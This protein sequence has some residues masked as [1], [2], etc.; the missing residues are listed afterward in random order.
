MFS[1]I[2]KKLSCKILVMDKV[3]GR[4]RERREGVDWTYMDG[5]G[6]WGVFVGIFSD[7]DTFLFC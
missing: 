1:V 7:S 3:P 6:D 5:D 4:E 2:G